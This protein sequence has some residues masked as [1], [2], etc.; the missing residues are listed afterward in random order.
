MTLGRA[1]EYPSIVF[2][3]D[4]H[5]FLHS[6]ELEIEFWIFGEYHEP[7]SGE[8]PPSVLP[9]GSIRCQLSRGVIETTDPS[10]WAT[11][12]MEHVSRRE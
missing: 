12:T 5:F 9:F 11:T 6:P 3:I 10:L 4:S 8:A 1:S 7:R 2:I